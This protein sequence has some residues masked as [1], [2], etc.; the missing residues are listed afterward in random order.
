MLALALFT[1]LIQQALSYMT[2]LVVPMAAPELARVLGV[3]VSL[4]GYY[5]GL[6]FAATM[7][8]MLM[9][10]GAIRRFGAVRMSQVSLG[11]S[12]LGLLL[13][14]TGEVWALALGGVMVGMFI[15]ISTPASSDILARYAPPRYAALIFSIKQAGVPL[16]G[17]LAGLLVPY[18][19]VT[20]GWRGVFIGTGFL[21]I[22]PAIAMQVL[23]GLYDTNR[24]LS[25]RFRL[26]QAAETLDGVI[27]R[28]PFR[29][30]AMTVFAYCGLQ[31]A[32][33]T[34]FVSMLVT[35][36][37][38]SLVAAGAIF[39]ISQMAAVFARIA[40]GWIAGLVG[41]A[42][43]VLAAL[44]VCMAMIAGSMVMMVPGWP[45]FLV[46]LIAIG[47]SATAISWHGV[48]LS[49]IA[50]RSR[51]EEVAINTGGVLAFAAAGQFMYPLALGVWIGAGMGFGWGFALL[52][53]PALG[54]GIM[55]AARELAE[56]RNR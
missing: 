1:M 7:F 56:A 25:H 49:A 43:P 16:G 21:C 26:G 44:G 48:V 19:M 42:R 12:G 31:G 39:S 28:A 30:L 38:Y 2:A 52:G 54:V 51:P 29:R 46:M 22:V 34:F 20:Y 11:G 6:M 27:R 10:G 47:Y 4:T 9:V 40:W 18:L 17:I 32:F 53:L 41:R 15:A 5:S 33:A 14:L 35:E 45:E 23:R 3:D 36:L 13:G 55:F 50:E 8:S 37:E 24:D